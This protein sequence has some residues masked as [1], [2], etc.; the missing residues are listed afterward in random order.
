ME[1][2]PKLCT[3]VVLKWVR[4]LRYNKKGGSRIAARLFS[5]RAAFG[6][7]SVYICSGTVILNMV[8]TLKMTRL[9]ARHRAIRA[10]RVA[11]SASRMRQLL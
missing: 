11:G 1:K 7:F 8:S 6:A 5:S 3:N 4:L 10:C 2:T 9:T